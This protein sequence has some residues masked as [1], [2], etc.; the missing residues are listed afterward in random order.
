MGL[1]GPGGRDPP[2]AAAGLLHSPQVE[3]TVGGGAAQALVQDGA[4]NPQRDPHC[5]LD[6]VSVADSGHAASCLRMTRPG[7]CV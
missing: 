4:S 2:V 6:D 1:G 5:F 7:V 3:V